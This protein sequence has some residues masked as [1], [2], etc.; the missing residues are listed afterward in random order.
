VT[1]PNVL[2]IGIAG[3]GVAFNFLANNMDRRSHLRFQA[4][5][6]PRA[7]A[8]KQFA[9]RFGGEVYADF[10]ALCR[11]PN[12][13]VVYIATPNRLHREQAIIA[14][15]HGKHVIVDKPIALTLEDCDAMITAAE[16][17]NVKLMCGHSHS[18]DP[19]II[20]M[21][22][23]IAQGVVGQ[24][25]MI[26]TWNFNDWLYRP[27]AHWEL[28]PGQG[29]NIIYNQGSHQ[30]DIVR[31]LGGGMMR[32][33]RAITGVWDPAR[34]IE[35]AYSVLATFDDGAAATLVNN[36]HGHFDIAE[37]TEWVGE[38]YRN[39]DSIAN[40]RRRLAALQQGV[41]ENQGKEVSR[42]GGEQSYR[43]SLPPHSL[44]GLTVVSCDKADLRQSPRGLIV[45]RDEGREDVTLDPGHNAS[46]AALENMF[47]VFFNDAP[48][49]RDGRWGKATVE[50]L[51][52]I[53]Q[54]SREAREIILHHQ[55]PSTLG[56][57]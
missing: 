28:E 40:T 53:A 55:V 51:L 48:V 52:A 35:G 42:F 49:L 46:I 44:Y 47:D 23:M 25:R 15:N 36:G 43:P 38:V 2:R 18:Y 29:G 14:A 56:A 5:M 20:A 50:V 10:E 17:N 39:E 31:F 3:L 7:D 30:V 22:R 34:K 21:R 8:L 33:V 4:G 54:S 16:R 6:D 32:S 24:L 13:D 12:I 41:G 27:R 45:H 37:M 26:N 9:D 57:I 1:A 19:S 11:S